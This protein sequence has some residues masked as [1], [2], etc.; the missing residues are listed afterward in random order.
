MPERLATWAVCCAVLGGAATVGCASGEGSAESVACNR[1]AQAYCE[2]QKT[3]IPTVFSRDYGDAGRCL[4]QAANFCAQTF[5]PGSADS[6]EF[7][8]DCAATMIVADC[9]VWR[10][11]GID[12]ALPPGMLN[13]GMP[14][15]DDV[16]C[17]GGWCS[18]ADPGTCGTCRT[19]VGMDEPCDLSTHCKDDMDCHGVGEVSKCEPL[20]DVGQAC[21]P[22]SSRCTYGL[23][24]SSG[25]ICERPRGEGEECKD[26]DCNFDLGLGCNNG[27]CSPLTLITDRHGCDDPAVSCIAGR[28]CV[29][30][31]DSCIDDVLEG[32][33]CKPEIGLFCELGLNC[34]KGICR[35]VQPLDCK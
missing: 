18:G 16:Q 7:T 11:T 26:Y 24:C 23:I 19:T 21:D 1:Y 5:L 2:R 10:S 31:T 6:P 35:S 22:F 25:L 15:Q 8:T 20:L 33:E 27:I 9:D 3:C 17:A 29:N 30:Q 28:H 12:C 13:D 4:R 14:C 32:Q 34:V